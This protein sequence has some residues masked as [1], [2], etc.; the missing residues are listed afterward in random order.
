MKILMKYPPLPN[1]GFMLTVPVSVEMLLHPRTTVMMWNA[2]CQLPCAL[3]PA[4]V[5]LTSTI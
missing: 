1:T 2:C 3:Q 5:D 4:A